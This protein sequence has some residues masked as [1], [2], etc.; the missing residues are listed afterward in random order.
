MA[1]EV[2][3]NAA[4]ERFELTADGTPAGYIEYQDTGAERALVH[5]EVYPRFEGRG[6]ANT[7]AQA[8]LDASR[9]EGFSVLPLCPMVLHFVKTHPEYI[10]LVPQRARALFGLPQ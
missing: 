4:L 5:T 2:R 8:A 10:S 1:T 7:L 6:L 3:N 9:A